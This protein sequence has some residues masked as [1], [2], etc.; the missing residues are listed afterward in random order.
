MQALI[1]RS[2]AVVVALVLAI[3]MAACSGGEQTTES[4]AAEPTEPVS[5]PTSE[6]APTTESAPTETMSEM[7]S[8]MASEGSSESGQALPADPFAD[9]K[10]AAQAVGNM[11]S[12]KTLAAGI[13]K[14][15]SMNGN[16]DSAAAQTLATLS[17]LLQEHVYLTGYAVDAGV[18]FGLDSPAFEAAAAALDENSVELSEVVTSVSDEQQGQAFLELWRQHIGFFVNYTE[19]KATDDQQMVDEALKSLG[20]Y[21]QQA[22]AFF[23]KVS[24][25]AIPAS[26]VQKSL[27]GHVNTLTAAIDA[28]VAGQ[29]TAFNELKQAADHIG[30][31]GSAMA[32]AAGFAKAAGMD[33]NVESPAATTLATLSTLLEEHVYL[34]GLTVK[35]AYA[36]GLDSQ[37]FKAAEKVLDENTVE[38]SK[39]V[40]SVAGEQQ[41]NAF[42][43]LW[44]QHIGFFVDY[45]KGAAAGDDQMKQAALDN[46]DQYRSQAGAFF[47][48]ISGGAIPASAVEEN[49]VKHV[50][51]LSTAIDS[52]AAV[53]T[54]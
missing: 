4:N 16:V 28:I 54:Q 49:L 52:L 11:G 38:L 37:A 34:S 30:E 36:A 22:G 27:Q 29:P 42:R 35:T 12:A 25:G 17:T 44:R 50:Q 14:A 19:G 2:G 39:V 18:N 9:V 33:G 40:G 32:L 43:E 6:S 24:G 46:L 41:G 20:D 15:T 8:E 13:A 48:Q 7:A 5:E 31:T 3:V 21:R 23:E 26:A 53:L 47:E 1:K 45:A 51:T 10:V